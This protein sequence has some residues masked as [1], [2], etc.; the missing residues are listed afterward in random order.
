MKY[1][2]I[3][4]SLFLAFCLGCTLDSVEEAEFGASCDGAS[5][6]LEDSGPCKIGE[7]SHYDS[8]LH[9]GRCP[10]G[11]QCIKDPDDG[12]YCGNTCPAG[13]HTYRDPE[14]TYLVCEVDSTDNC[15]A[16]GNDC[17]S[18]EGWHN[19]KCEDGKCKLITC[20]GTFHAVDNECKSLR[21]CCGTSCKDCTLV[22]G[23][24]CSDGD[25]VESK[26]KSLD[27]IVCDGA[28]I[29]PAS[30]VSYC[31]S[32]DSCVL[33]ECRSDQ[34]CN[35]SKCTCPNGAD[36]CH[37]EC[38]DFE[39]TLEL[40]G[41]WDHHCSDMEGWKDG[42]CAKGICVPAE[43]VEG[44]HIEEVDGQDVCVKNSVTACGSIDNNCQNSIEGWQ[45]GECQSGECIVTECK[46]GYFSHTPENSSPMICIVNNDE[47]CGSPDNACDEEHECNTQKAECECKGSTMQC[48][49][50]HCYDLNSDANNCGACGNVCSRPNAT[51]SCSGGSCSFTCEADYSE[52][53][54]VCYQLK[55]DPDHC[56]DCNTKCSVS[57]ADNSCVE[58]QCKFSCHENFVPAQDNKSCEPFVCSENQKRC[59]GNVL[60]ICK[61]NNWETEQTCQAPA[62]ASVVCDAAKGCGFTCENKYVKNSDGTGCEEFVCNKGDIKC[63]GLGYKTCSNN[64]WTSKSFGEEYVVSRSTSKLSCPDKQNCKTGQTIECNNKVKGHYVVKS[65]NTEYLRVSSPFDGWVLAAD[66][67][68]AGTA[69]SACT[70]YW[71]PGTA[72]GATDF[73]LP[74]GENVTVHCTG[75]ADNTEWLST[76]WGWVT[77]NCFSNFGSK[78]DNVPRC[79]P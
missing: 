60:Q 37:G 75:M 36:E 14:V 33:H 58:G 34:L 35:D 24:V 70:T 40:C 31:G 15:G 59:S 23:M 5:Y 10:K 1:I 47:H 39:T 11:F 7:C 55:S 2:L 57:D 20:K 3:I 78:L 25:C 68:L 66:V 63:D 18:K 74:Q 42:D 50:G 72:S 29:N 9:Q 44:Y 19:G 45:D 79:T 46:Q 56:G 41:A 76:D 69:A 51:A 21:Q 77:G 38:I 32:D 53:D 26:C 61:K 43:C 67:A 16:H 22:A 73:R 64:K 12:Y 8:Y 54:S 52:C 17:L 65:N 30:N 27:E 13:Y 4:S 28:C 71:A 48:E 49:D 6:V 62:H